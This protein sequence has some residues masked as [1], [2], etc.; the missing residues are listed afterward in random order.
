MNADQTPAT[1]NSDNPSA[2]SENTISGA[3]DFT[4]KETQT[5]TIDGVEYTVTNDSNS[6]NSLSWTKDTTTGQL[7]FYCSNVTIVAQKDVAHDL[8]IEGLEYAED[9]TIETI[10]HVFVFAEKAINK[11]GTSI[12]KATLPL[13][14]TAKEFLIKLADKIDGVEGDLE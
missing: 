5:I 11:Y 12:L 13:L 6:S 1:I 7:S 10:E 9:V 14:Q 2:Q 8:K 4:A 3:V